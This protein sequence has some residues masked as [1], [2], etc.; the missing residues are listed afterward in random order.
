MT[1]MSRR[2]FVTESAAVAGAAFLA[3][4]ADNLGSLQTAPALPKR[5]FGST[6][7]NLTAVGFGGGSRFYVTSMDDEKAAELVRQAIDR[8]MGIVETAAN[9]GDGNSERRI[10]MAMKTHRSK[11][12]L[13]TKVDARDY[14]GAMREIERSLTRLQTDKLD[15]VLHHFITGHEQIDRVLASDGAERAIRKMVDQKVVRYHGFSCHL[16]A[17][18]RE[19]IERL[20]PQAIQLPINATRVPDFEPDALPFAK[21]R[22]VAVIAMKTSGVGYFLRNNFTKPDRIDRYGPP[23][24]AFD[25]PNLPTASDYL[26]YALSLPVTTVVVGIDCLQ[27][28]ESVIEN[29]SRFRPLSASDMASISKRAQVFATTGFWIPGARPRTS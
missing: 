21:S 4:L 2:Q 22:G 7:I 13:E 24:D 16:P 20:D 11:V 15:L 18:A 14:D 9:Y 1:D 19:G 10:G 27:T 12:F 17:I 3:P 25:P 6:G 29:A 23:P 5:P 28:L 8:G 26:S